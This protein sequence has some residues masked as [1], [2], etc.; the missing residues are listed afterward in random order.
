MV[1]LIGHNI[2]ISSFLPLTEFH[3]EERPWRLFVHNLSLKIP[4]TTYFY[5]YYYCYYYNTGH[6]HCG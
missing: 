2:L 6:S 5:Y 4:Q 3:L 1:C